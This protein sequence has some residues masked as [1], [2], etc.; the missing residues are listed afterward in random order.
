ML[1][2]EVHLIL[3]IVIEFLSLCFSVLLKFRDPT[4][5]ITSYG[6]P[7]SGCTQLDGTSSSLEETVG[8]GR[9]IVST[10]GSVVPIKN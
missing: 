4:L 10:T 3:Q 8:K 5:L 7:G 9:Q 6:P 1:Q 2:Q